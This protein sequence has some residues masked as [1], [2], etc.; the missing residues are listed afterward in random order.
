M[1]FKSGNMDVIIIVTYIKIIMHM[2]NHGGNLNVLNRDNQT[3]LMFATTK[4]LKD[5]GLEE[6]LC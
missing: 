1:A 6:G 2:L 5:L 3:P 4:I